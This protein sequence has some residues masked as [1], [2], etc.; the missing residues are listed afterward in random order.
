MPFGMNLNF[1]FCFIRRF[2]LGRP[3]HRVKV[4]RTAVLR[5]LHK[6]AT[7]E[8]AHLIFLGIVPAGRAGI[9]TQQI[10]GFLAISDGRGC[11][12]GALSRLVEVDGEN[13]FRRR[14]V[15]QVQLAGFHLGQPLQG[16]QDVAAEGGKI[17][18]RQGIVLLILREIGLFAAPEQHQ[19][20]NDPLYK[21]RRAVPQ[22][23][24][25]QRKPPGTAFKQSHDWAGKM[26]SAAISGQFEANRRISVNHRRFLPVQFNFFPQKQ[27]KQPLQGSA[28][29]IQGT[30]IAGIDES[31]VFGKRH[32][33]V[34]HIGFQGPE[35]RLAFFVK[36]GQGMPKGERR[37]V[38]RFRAVL[39]IP[40]QQG[41]ILDDQHP[42]AAHPALYGQFFVGP[43]KRAFQAD[44][45][46]C[47]AGE[48]LLRGSVGLHHLG[49]FGIRGV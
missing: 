11:G 20:R 17:L 16:G 49:Q 7:D 45:P 26:R 39:H 14:P 27:G 15:V 25:I 12:N 40:N 46:F 30:V 6:I 18:L 35:D 1:F 10:Q 42:L 36:G 32:E 28:E 29:E 44:G 22:L 31:A 37:T 19:Q 48:V 24:L 8:L 2:R 38:C 3:D 34:L 9:R 5:F 47:A 23:I 33:L 21:F 43:G 4:R 13:G 41:Q